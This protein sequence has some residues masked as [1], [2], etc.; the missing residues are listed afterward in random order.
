MKKIISVVLSLITASGCFL[1][2]STAQKN[3]GVFAE[4]RSV[5]DEYIPTQTVY[6]KLISMKEEYPEG[7]PW[8]NDNRYRWNGGIYSMGG[9][10]VAFAF[11][12]SDSVFGN[13]PARK[14]TDF[15][16]VK[17]GDIIRTNNDTHSV[18]VL[19]KE[20]SIVT[21][22][23]GNFN[24]SV[25]WGRKIDLSANSG[26]TYVLTRYP[27]C[28][29]INGDYSVNADDASLVLVEYS[30][31]STSSSSTFD[32][33]KK[34]AADIDGNGAINSADASLILGFYAYLST[35]NNTSQI[36]IREWMNK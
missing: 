28:G 17:V 29:D 32:D 36:D 34:W 31:L 15:S 30:A 21:I 23:E 11:T 19:K 33:R 8:T 4:D 9:G 24:S 18:I 7:M 20:G 5:Y 10:C 1:Y 2:G 3:S 6:D 27:E 22:A 13:L 12:L 35:N 16:R 25:H 14:H 26:L